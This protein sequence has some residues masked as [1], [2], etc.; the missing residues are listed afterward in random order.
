MVW[1]IFF[2]Y[3]SICFRNQFYRVK[4]N[5]ESR[6]LNTEMFP[7]KN[8][9]SFPYLSLSVDQFW[10][11]KLK[12]HRLRKRAAKLEMVLEDWKRKK[13]RGEVKIFDFTHDDHLS[14]LERASCI[15][16]KIEFWFSLCQDWNALEFFNELNRFGCADFVNMFLLFSRYGTTLFFVCSCNRT[17]ADNFISHWFM[18]Y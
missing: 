8:T 18:T 11:E 13:W 15:A 12:E 5:Q 17:S 9:F 2:Y 6:Q 3:Y 16:C 1:K 10:S 7:E 4:L 14:F